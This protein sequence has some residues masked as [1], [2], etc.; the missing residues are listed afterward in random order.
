M[1]SAEPLM[2]KPK[3]LPFFKI[4]LHNDDNNIADDVAEKLVQITKL[5]IQDAIRVTQEAH[6]TGI[7]LVKVVHREL[8]ELYHEQFTSCG[9]TTTIEPE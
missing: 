7:A 5:S 6:K 4:L 3:T 2:S 1:T 8:A 9:I